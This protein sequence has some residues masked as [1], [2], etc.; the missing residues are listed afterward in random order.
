MDS[1]NG[2]AP[3]LVKRAWAQRVAQHM[4]GLDEE[5]AAGAPAKQQFEVSRFYDIRPVLLRS[6]WSEDGGGYVAIASFIKDSAGN[7][8]KGYKFNVYAIP[9]A[10]EPE[11]TAD[12]TR[13]F[14]VWRGRWEIIPTSESILMPMSLVTNWTLSGSIYTATA[15]P[16]I[17]DQV[18]TSTTVTVY[19]P[20]FTSTPPGE[21]GAYRFWAVWRNARWE[22]LESTADDPLFMP[23]RLQT[24]WSKVNGIYRA[25][26]KFIISDSGTVS[27]ETVTVYAPTFT[28]TPP[29]KTTVYKFWAV[30][31]NN[32]WE[33]LQNVETLAYN[34]VQLK[35][36]WVKNSS[37]IWNAT[38]NAITSTGGVSTTNTT[39]YAP[40]FP[41]DTTPP[42]TPGASRFWI[43]WRNNRWESTQGT[44]TAQ[45]ETLS[46]MVLATSWTLGADG[47]Y[48]A[49]AHPLDG[50]GTADTETTVTVY[51]PANDPTTQRAP[52]GT[53]QKW[54]FWAVYR[55]NRWE[56]IQPNFPESNEVEIAPFALFTEWTRTN[57]A[58][59]YKATAKKIIDDTGTTE[60]T[61]VD[62]Y[63]PAGVGGAP[64]AGK[65]G[66]DNTGQGLGYWKFWAV[67]RNNRWE[68]LQVK[69]PTVEQVEAQAM[70][71]K[72]SWTKSG[73]VY[74]ATANPIDS[75]TGNVDT[76]TTLT[77][78]APQFTDTPPGVAGSYRF[79]AVYQNSRWECL[80]HVETLGYRLVRLATSW[81]KSGNIYTATASPV[82]ATG[83]VDT[84][85]TLTIYAPQFSET[86]PGT[87][88][89]T[90]LWVVWN[91]NRWESLQEEPQKNDVEI[92]PFSLYSDWTQTN[93]A[94]TYKAT[95]K[96]ILDDSG[97]L[98]SEA[99]DVY[100]PAG[101][102]G[103]PPA[104][105]AGSDTSGQ[106]LGYWKFWAVYRNNRWE[107]LQLPYPTVSG[108]DKYVA[109]LGIDIGA[110]S[111][112]QG[113]YPINNIG[114]RSVRISGS[115][116]EAKGGPLNCS[117]SHFKW[118]T[119]TLS[120]ETELILK[121][122]RLK[123]VTDVV[124]GTPSYKTVELIGTN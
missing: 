115:S 84:S 70:R 117:S 26:A 1:L 37:G 116:Y 66:N 92:A 36:A 35:T 90:K 63:A 32:R 97:T 74:T 21:A 85:T 9:G 91:N 13:L 43:A 86:P 24:A 44:D 89:T 75:T 48:Y 67:Y 34:C 22:F 110:Y 100:A 39:V 120:G 17:N 99:V 101:V 102:G 52:E 25:T 98:D 23:M 3:V 79:W 108:G 69:N 83:E 56:T 55:N 31:R 105:K 53:N 123:I 59:T 47:I 11:G 88:G 111:S 12:V 103:K 122:Y 62:V 10:P 16:I 49:S 68:S 80:Q 33:S 107:S 4:T 121:T 109:G 29:G 20:T 14:A 42:G 94:G 54:R 114:V 82:N 119:S 65:P 30:W 60:T 73:N 5:I 95:A 106:G 93:S 112:A 124:N 7:I 78:Y 118:V 41:S 51:A 57:S 46:P 19:A 45:G 2:N 71:L 6:G 27:S 104:G 87:N 113:G 58:N 96:R 8:E 61:A 50:T 40:Q 18:D 81:T 28:S 76:S 64:P 72:S 77:I 38:T 15:N